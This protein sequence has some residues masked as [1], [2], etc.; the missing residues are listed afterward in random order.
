MNPTNLIL[1]ALCFLIY[2]VLG[3]GGHILLNICLCGLSS[4]STK[5]TPKEYI[6][7][8]FL[9]LPRL[10]SFLLSMIIE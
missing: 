8:G 9:W 5:T 4:T 2:F 6:M 7:S 1:I 10:L 3:V